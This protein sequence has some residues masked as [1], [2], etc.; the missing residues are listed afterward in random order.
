MDTELTLETAPAT[1]A[2]P[3]ALPTVLVTSPAASTA[4]SEFASA[5]D[6]LG[7]APRTAERTITINGKARRLTMRA[8]DGDAY[9]A[10]LAKHPATEAQKADGYAFDVDRFGPAILAA[11]IVTPAG[12]PVLTFEQ[13]LQ[14]WRSPAW[15]RG[16]RSDLFIA[17]LDLCTAGL[18]VPFTAAG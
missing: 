6:L 11:C 13:A 17:C 12:A 5:E 7:K 16:E 10:L 4:E 9:D 1:A 18:D 15:S 3:V 14:L 8:L 2:A